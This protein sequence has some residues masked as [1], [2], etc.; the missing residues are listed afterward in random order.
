MNLT[1][2]LDGI[3]D[4]TH[5]LRPFDTDAFRANDKRQPLYVIASAV[6]NGGRGQME[7]VAF[8]A[9]DGDFFGLNEE[10]AASSTQGNKRV[11]WYRRIFLILRF[12]PYSIVLALRKVFS[13]D[14]EQS[15]SPPM[16]DS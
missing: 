1:Y 5:G 3:L 9:K 10:N 7:T 4:E 11:S 14:T 8:N 2:V 15:F 6:N 12:V 13:S 16:K